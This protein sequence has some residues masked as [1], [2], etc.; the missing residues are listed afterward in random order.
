MLK[1]L[2][3]IS[4]DTLQTVSDLVTSA[5]F[6][7]AVLRKKFNRKSWNKIVDH[8]LESPDER[9]KNAGTGKCSSTKELL[10]ETGRTKVGGSGVRSGVRS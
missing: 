7:K 4:M 2:E 3:L 8:D 5:V 6:G 10:L 9:D 1:Q